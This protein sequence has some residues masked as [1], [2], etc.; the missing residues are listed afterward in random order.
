MIELIAF[1]TKAEIV[2]YLKILQA[3]KSN[4]D[5]KFIFWDAERWLIF[6]LNTRMPCQILFMR[7]YATSQSWKSMISYVVKLFSIALFKGKK[8]INLGLLSIPGY[9]PTFMTNSWV[10]DDISY[11]L[12]DNFIERDG[13]PEINELRL[14]DPNIRLLGV[15]GFMSKRK[16]PDF[17]IQVFQH[18]QTMSNLNYKL[19]FFGKVDID[20]QSSIVKWREQG[21]IVFDEYFE[22][23]KY[24]RFLVS[25]DC[26]L[27]N[28]SNVG[29]S[30]VIVD[31]LSSNTQVVFFGSKFWK[32][33]VSDNRTMIK[34]ADANPSIFAEIVVK[35]APHRVKNNYSIINRFPKVNVIDF[36]L[37]M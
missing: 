5:T 6:L 23:E 34:F 12:K 8:N 3:G 13:L 15:P 10:D 32:N 35:F 16:N 36:F 9:K 4:K 33:F 22:D 29:S 1:S 20:L 24:R 7:P 19:I 28:Y 11:G 37:L 25:L 18:I 27:V 2:R 17:I 21:V 26:V 30:G 31:A 14:D